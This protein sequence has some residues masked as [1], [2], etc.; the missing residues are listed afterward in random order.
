M[1]GPSHLHVVCLEALQGILLSY[2]HSK[3]IIV[4]VDD[5]SRNLLERNSTDCAG[6]HIRLKT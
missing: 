4:S 5:P 1:V 6:N 2:L 3:R